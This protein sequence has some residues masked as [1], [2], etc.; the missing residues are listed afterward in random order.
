MNIKVIAAAVTVVG[1]T[2]GAFAYLGPSL[3]TTNKDAGH[4]T[5]IAPRAT[6]VAPRPQRALPDISR[7]S[8]GSEAPALPEPIE[9]LEPTAAR[10]PIE[11]GPPLNADP[12]AGTVVL[13]TPAAPPVEFGP[14]MDA[15]D[16]LAASAIPDSATPAEIG[17]E[18]DADDP[19]PVAQADVDNRPS[20]EIG[21]P[22]LAD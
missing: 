14:P 13:Q 2:L 9:S 12:L 21:S 7:Y 11:V 10:P 18:L 22:L 19:Y 8:P 16:E 5:P 3:P 4:R 17:H 20:Q 1:A 6:A 15:D